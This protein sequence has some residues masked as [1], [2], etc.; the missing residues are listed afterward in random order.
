MACG[1]ARL[2][3]RV[4]L[5]SPSARRIPDP[6]REEIKRFGGKYEEALDLDQDHFNE[7]IADMDM[8]YLPGCSAP[9]GTEA[10]AFKKSMDDYLVRFETLEQVYQ[11]Q[12]KIIYVT[13]TLPRRA[14]EMDLRIDTMPNQLYF[15]AITFSISIRMALIASILGAQD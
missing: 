8:V 5:A 9:K 12:G 1:L 7:L 10:E 14:G 15:E 11:K 3:A 4:T 2:G 13:H 6:V